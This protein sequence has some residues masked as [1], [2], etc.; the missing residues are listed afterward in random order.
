MYKKTIKYT[1]FNGVE[2]TEDFY[3]NLSATELM[4]M[5]VSKNGGLAE[6]IVKASKENDMKTIFEIVT[7]FIKKSYGV[8]SEDGKR[9]D[10]N[11]KHFEE[12]SQSPAYDALFMELITDDTK[13]SEFI[14]G[15]VP[16]EVQKAMQSNENKA[17][18]E[19]MLNK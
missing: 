1:D 7:E 4:Q 16:A 12:F 8:R 10:K 2:C 18:L 11:P 5:Q 15:V 14:N 6:S 13:A 19:T 17:A 3:F 9:F